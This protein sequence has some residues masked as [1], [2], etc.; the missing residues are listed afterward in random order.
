MK[1][2]F[3]D[4]EQVSLR[5]APT[6]KQKYSWHISASYRLFQ[7]R[8]FGFLQRSLRAGA[9]KQNPRNDRRVSWDA[10][11][12][13]FAAELGSAATNV[14]QVLRRETSPPFSEHVP[15]TSPS[16][17]S[18]I[19]LFGCK[20]RACEWWTIVFVTTS[21]VRKRIL[22]LANKAYSLYRTMHQQ[23]SRLVQQFLVYEFAKLHRQLISHSVVNKLAV[24]VTRNHTR[25][26]EQ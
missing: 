8:T 9:G 26:C 21:V 12:N 10:E 25:R 5:Y 13:G 16:I 14:A 2:I 20:F 19:S 18:C 11:P 1:K 23:R 4:I 24:F 22:E 6:S 15:L 7:L 3:L 17:S